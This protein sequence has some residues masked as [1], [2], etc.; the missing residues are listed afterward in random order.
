MGRRSKK[1]M[2]RRI[3]YKLQVMPL[4]R[5]GKETGTWVCAGI[6]ASRYEARSYRDAHFPQAARSTIMGV[7]ADYT[8]LKPLGKSDQEEVKV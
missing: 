5:N 8:P 1:P 3:G 4:G 2:V 6:F 7:R